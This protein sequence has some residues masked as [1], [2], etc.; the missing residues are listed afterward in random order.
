[1]KDM[2]TADSMPAPSARQPDEAGTTTNPGA[3]DPL[4]A[5]VFHIREIPSWAEPFSN[6]LIT[7]DLPQDEAEARR[8]QRRAGAYTIINSELYKRS[9]S[10]IFQ[11]CIEP[12]EGIELLREI[13]QGECGHHASF[14]ALVAKAFR[15]GFYW[16]TA[17]QNA[18]QLVKQCNGCQRFSKHRNTP[19]QDHPAHLAVHSL[20]PGHGWAIQDCTRGLDASVGCC[21]QVHQ[22][23]R[24]QAN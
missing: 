16:P 7:G 5:S 9:V 14:R 1:M 12:E 11:K 24:G 19:A 10:G 20:G 6:Y 17:K 4:V 8:I 15:H 13:H 23:D 2:G 18:E 3:A 21:G 22:V